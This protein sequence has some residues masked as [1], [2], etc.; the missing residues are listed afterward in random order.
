MEKSVYAMLRG[1]DLA[2][3]RNKEF[4]I[5]T[6]WMLDSG[7]VGKVMFLYIILSS[8][9]N[10]PNLHRIGCWVCMKQEL[11]EGKA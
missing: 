4:S 2:T 1:R 10:A 5:P 6:Q 3:T 8:E 7:L 11:E 9:F